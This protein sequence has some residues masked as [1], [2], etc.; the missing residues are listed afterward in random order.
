MSCG[1][2]YDLFS[3]SYLVITVATLK[4]FFLNLISSLIPKHPSRSF[5][6]MK[7]KFLALISSSSSSARTTIGGKLGQKIKWKYLEDH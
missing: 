7:N 1:H 3:M 2:G 6:Q 4:T 5:S